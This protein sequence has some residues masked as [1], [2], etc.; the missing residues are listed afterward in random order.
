[1]DPKNAKARRYGVVGLSVDALDDHAL[2]IAGLELLSTRALAARVIGFHDVSLA[3][4]SPQHQ[5][6]IRKTQIRGQKDDSYIKR[7]SDQDSDWYILTQK[8]FKRNP[9]SKYMEQNRPEKVG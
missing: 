7:K 6:Q 1:M 8:Y 5:R 9:L 4:C 2:Q 3:V